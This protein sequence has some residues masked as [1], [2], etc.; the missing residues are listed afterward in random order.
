MSAGAM[1]MSRATALPLA[2]EMLDALLP[3]CEP[4]RCVIAGSIRREC[5]LVGDVEIVAIPKPSAITAFFKAAA[6]IGAPQNAT[7]RESRYV[8]YH[9]PHPRLGQIQYDIFLPR[10]YDW[11][12]ILAI[13]T[14]SADFA[15]RMLASQWVKKGYRGTECGLLPENVCVS[16]SGKWSPKPGINPDIYRVSFPEEQDLFTWLGLASMPEPQFRNL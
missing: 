13:R 9:R 5:P 7:T 8:K 14:G 11:G 15:Q 4:G 3:Y 10:P 12:R 16:K 1:K 6:T 2:Q